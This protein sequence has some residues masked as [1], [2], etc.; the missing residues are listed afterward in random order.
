MTLRVPAAHHACRTGA[1]LVL[2]DAFEASLDAGS[3]EEAMFMAKMAEDSERY[4][5]AD[6]V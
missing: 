4:K 5:G 2:M 1:L 6:W 3:Y